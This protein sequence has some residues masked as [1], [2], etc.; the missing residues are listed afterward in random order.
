MNGS[1]LDVSWQP[2][3]LEDAGGFYRNRIILSTNE[4]NNQVVTLYIPYSES[5]TEFVGLEPFTNYTLTMSIVVIDTAEG[6]ELI[7]PNSEPI[8]VTSLLM[9]G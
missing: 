2:V 6:E 1:V 5:S 7:G 9:N 3:S 8:R 4:G